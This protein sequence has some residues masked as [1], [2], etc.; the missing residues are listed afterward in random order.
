M[1]E[2]KQKP[3]LPV[4]EAKGLCNDC[5]NNKSVIHEH[6]DSIVTCYCEH[7]LTGG[8]YQA[9]LGIWRLSTPISP[10]YF[11]MLSKMQ[12]EGIK[13]GKEM[14]KKKSKIPPRKF[15]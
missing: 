1:K 10:D 9:D 12:I 5:I 3:K 7:N 6:D 4:P 2:D 14:L 15:H 8:L 11:Q 13:K